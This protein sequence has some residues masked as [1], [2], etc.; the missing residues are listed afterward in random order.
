MFVPQLINGFTQ[1]SIYAL[2]AIG[3][4]IIFGIMNLVTFAHGKVYMAGAFAGYF[5]LAVWHLPWYIAVALAIADRGYLL[6]TGRIVLNDTAKNLTDNPM[7]RRAYL[8]L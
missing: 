7:M 2:I 3:F 6:Q 4:V 8:E 5:A 1:G